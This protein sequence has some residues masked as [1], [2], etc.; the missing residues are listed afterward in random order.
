MKQKSKLL[1]ALM[2][3]FSLIAAA[4]GSGDDDGDSGAAATTE[5]P[6]AAEEDAMEEDAMEDD[7]M[8]DE[9]HSADALPGAGVQVTAA[10]ANWSTGYFQGA[11][12]AAMLTELG[13]EV[14]DPADN[15]F[16]PSNGYTAMA[17]GVI[18]FWANSWYSGHLS[19][20]ENELTDGSTVGDKVV[21]LGEELP[22]AGLE[23]IMITKSVADEYGIETMGQIND[24]PE[25]TALFDQDGDGIAD[26]FGCPE[27]WT[28]DDIMNDILAFN[29]WDNIQQTKAGYDAMIAESVNRVN[30]GTPTLQY[31]WSPSGYLTQLIPGDNVLWLSMGDASNVLDGST[32]G[33]WNFSEAPPAALG[34]AC[35][36]DP[37]YLGWESADIQI[38]A[39][40]EFADN[41]PAAR[42]LFE[43]VQLNVIDVAL[44]N[45]KY[46][47]GENSE[48][49][50]KRHAAE[51]IAENR[52]LVDSW[53]EVARAAA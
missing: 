33:G 50:V 49:D 3:A 5:A 8:E 17:E 12:Y 34:D 15:E 14:S 47:N 10:R 51:W 27:D 22:A 20:H 45:V 39:N 44:Q 38:T 25:L 42:A 24:D 9:D 11:L 43:V 1:F 32:E 2:M 52:D 37:C 31:T 40:K 13:Y 36:A 6:A 48:D 19:W 26:L 41:N 46:N 18:D 28:C 29:G 21:I 30:A 35:T 23:G 16:P 7:A 4:C 53:L